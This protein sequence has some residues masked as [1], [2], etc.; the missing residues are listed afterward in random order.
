M[1]KHS[2]PNQLTKREKEIV[3]L[4][5]EAS[6]RKMIADALGIS[7]RTVDTHL[8]NVHLKTNTSNSVGVAN[9]NLE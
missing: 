3:R 8:K 7:I 2:K 1:P 9:L 5:K 6:S 4:I